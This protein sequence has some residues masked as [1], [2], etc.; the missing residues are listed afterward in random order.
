MDRGDRGDRV[1]PMVPM[2]PQG[3]RGQTDRG[4]PLRTGIRRIV[5]DWTAHDGAGTG[6]VNRDDPTRWL[7][8]NHRHEAGARKEDVAD[9]V[10][11]AATR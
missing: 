9:V 11:E 3:S 2:V 10:V 8:R 5:R 6:I 1:D 7:R 4:R